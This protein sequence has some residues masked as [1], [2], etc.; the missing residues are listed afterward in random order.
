MSAV[1]IE[2][3]PSHKAT[4]DS[5]SRESTGEE[6]ESLPHPVYAPPTA[7]LR[8]VMGE[9]WVERYEAVRR[10]AIELEKQDSLNYGYENPIWKYADEKLSEFR[11]KHPLGVIICMVLG[12]NRASKTEWRSK[13]LVQNMLSKPHYKAWACHATQESSREAQQNKIYKYI[14][15]E[16][17]PD[18]GRYR[19]GKNAKVVYT[20]WGGFTED[21]FSFPSNVEG[22]SEC[23]FKFYGMNPRSLEGGEI[24]EGWLDEESPV[25]WLDALIWRATTRNG[26]IYLTFTAKNGFT[27]MVKTILNGARTVE[28]VP[29]GLLPKQNLSA[30]VESGH[31]RSHRHGTGCDNPAVGQADGGE[32]DRLTPGISGHSESSVSPA[33]SF[34]KVPRLQVNENLVIATGEEG[35]NKVKA[36]ALIVYFHTSDNL[37]GNPESV[38]ATLEGASRE[39]ILTTFYGVPTQSQVSQ[40]P[41][42]GEKH[43]VSLNLFREIQ[44]NGGSWFHYVDPSSGR[45]W[46]QIWVFIDALHRRFVAAENPSHGHDWAYVPGIGM[47]EPWA[48]PGDPKDGIRG[49]GQ[50]E[51]GWGYRQYIEEIER[52]EKLL[53][54]DSRER[55]KVRERWMDARYGNARKTDE[56]N[57]TTTIVDMSELGMN[58]LAAPSE[59]SLTGARSDGSLRMINDLLFY[60]VNRP[61]DATNTPHL[62]VVETCPNVIWALQNWTGQDGQK[63]AS[64][65]PID[66]LRMLALTDADYVDER[67]MRP[68]IP[69]HFKR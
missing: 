38:A 15:P 24:D 26:I 46:F 41:L 6:Q 68:V 27:P 1:A 34:E 28:E 51:W 52:I 37:Y 18:S 4:A 67:A 13:R 64:K 3:E 60:D 8:A 58:F 40:F 63:G 10:Q 25:E 43:I 48:L 19:A 69:G 56:E 53:A 20:P 12:G 32:N 23:R 16:Y 39:K 33:Q 44:R 55:I 62:F 9:D 7:E 42:F 29:A 22:T 50:K 54:V 59:K 47:P 45:N 17:R 57:P 66:V 5:S 61:I 14:P 36:K 35:E 2:Q 30:G 49:G 11:K 65:D 21:V 31:V